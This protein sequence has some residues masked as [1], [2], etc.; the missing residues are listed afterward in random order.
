M[1]SEGMNKLPENVQR[2]TTPTLIALILAICF[3]SFALSYNKLHVLAERMDATPAWLWPLLLDSLIVVSTLMLVVVPPIKQMKHVRFYAWITLIMFTT[4]SIA[5]NAA[6]A[7]MATVERGIM[8]WVAIG[9][10]IMPPL[11]LFL[12]SHLVSTFWVASRK[13]VK[14]PKTG[15]LKSVPVFD[16]GLEPIKRGRGRPPGSKNKT[17]TEPQIALKMDEN[18]K[19]DTEVVHQDQQN[20]NQELVH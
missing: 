7:Y 10:N 11:A 18:Q 15:A 16:G 3:G 4:A 13:E 20:T 19:S 8:M 2:F 17:K 5:G 12:T 14:A 6:V 1:P 9:V